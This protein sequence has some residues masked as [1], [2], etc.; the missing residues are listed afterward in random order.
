MSYSKGK[1]MNS[2]KELINRIKSLSEIKPDND[3]AVL[4]KAR[5]VGHEAIGQKRSIMSIL[6]DMLLQYRIALAGLLVF[7]MA[8]GT[9]AVAQNALPGEPLYGLK[10]AT[11]KGVALVRGNDKVAS[12][13]LELAAK[14]LEEISRM[15]QKNLVKNLPA[16]FEE[17]KS[18][19]AEAK[20]KVVAAIKQNPE[21]AGQIVKD[22]AVAMKDIDDKERQVYSVLGLEQ[23][24]STTETGAETAS[25]QAI[26]ASLIEYLNDGASLT[27]DQTKDLEQVKALYETGNY[28]QALDKYLSSSLNK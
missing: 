3:W 10:R 1:T 28:S 9:V 23:N 5:I 14:R 24:A 13:N 20:D 21:N 27:E 25:D 22:A 6:G 18:A 11:E 16:A 2:D 15:S 19:K 17:Y 12:A 8:G 26:V 7:M 4:T